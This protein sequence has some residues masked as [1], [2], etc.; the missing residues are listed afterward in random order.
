MLDKDVQEALNRAN[1]A[2][3]K[4]DRVW[5][6]IRKI[7][8]PSSIV[9]KS[10]YELTLGTSALSI[11]IALLVLEKRQA[12]R[13]RKR[14]RMQGYKGITLYSDS[15]D[16][17]AD[18]E[19]LTT[20]TGIRHRATLGNGINEL[21]Q[22]GY[23]EKL[24]PVKDPKQ[25]F[26]PSVYRLLNPNTRLALVPPASGTLL[27]SND[28]HYFAVPECLF[29]ADASPS[30]AALTPEQKRLYVVLAWCANQGQ[31]N[32]FEMTSS[33]LQRLTGMG[34]QAVKN[35]MDG[36]E[37]NRLASE[38]EFGALFRKLHIHLYDP[39]TGA[40]LSERKRLV[41]DDNPR[42]WYEVGSKGT[43]HHVDFRVSREESESLLNQLLKERGQHATQSGDE[44]TLCCPFHDDSTPSCGFNSRKGCYHCFGCHARGTT[45][46]LLLALLNGDHEEYYKRIAAIRG[47]EIT[48][49]NPDADKTVYEYRDKYGRLRKQ[50]VVCWDE[51]GNKHF[52][53][54]IPWDKSPDGW[55]YKTDGRPMLFN[56][57]R[58]QHARLIVI[59]EGEKDATT[60]TN[61][62]M[63]ASGRQVV[64]TTSGGATTW[65]D[66]LVKNLNPLW[67]EIVVIPDNDEP[68]N[69]YGDAVMASLQKAGFTAKRLSLSG[70]GCKDVTEYVENNSSEALARFIG[71]DRIES[72]DGKRRK[73]P[74]SDSDSNQ[75]PLDPSIIGQMLGEI[76][77]I[78]I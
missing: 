12:V 13:N 70:T 20:L 1:H 21:V 25:R 65:K 58:I 34:S 38:Q 74:E 2:R 77:D 54:R 28:L 50:V 56:L 44:V 39:T 15:V 37:V 57:D 5:G 36:L 72:I 61:L 59:V 62:N 46:T 43:L 7:Q 78:H 35:A 22:A 29:T 48:L 8:L 18:G 27:H 33:Q 73:E 10:T 51:H 64:G 52:Q 14:Q 32:H 3:K 6:S 47:M 24:D 17:E 9:T 75:E 41:A 45:Q 19:T 66:K 42:N 55:L 11:L 4:E 31:T 53:Q 69:R 67:H 40:L 16:I 30:F 71:L 26:A 68:G 49:R 23:I 76:D 63:I 60:V